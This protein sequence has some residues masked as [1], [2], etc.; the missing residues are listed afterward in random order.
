MRLEAFAFGG[1]VLI[2]IR[3]EILT[4]ERV[5]G[6][7]PRMA[8]HRGLSPFVLGRCRALLQTAFVQPPSLPPGVWIP[9]VRFA[10]MVVAGASGASEPV[11]VP[12]F[13]YIRCAPATKF[14][15]LSPD[16]VAH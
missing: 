5:V 6:A 1:Q 14:A 2:N 7:T 11:M 10:E 3:P 13:N 8:Q 16:L 12:H 15:G 4:P 9:S